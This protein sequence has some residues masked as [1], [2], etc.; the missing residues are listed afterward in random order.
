MIGR[1]QHYFAQVVQP[2]WP[3]FQLNETDYVVQF[4]VFVSVNMIIMKSAVGLPQLEIGLP[5]RLVAQVGTSL[6][7]LH[8]RG[9]QVIR[10]STGPR[11][12]FENFSAPTAIHSSKRLVA[13]GIEEK[14]A[15][16]DR[17]LAQLEEVFSEMGRCPSLPKGL[18]L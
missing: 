4:I 3:A 18:L 12:P 8:T 5:H 13:Q 6:P 7:P 17:E 16:S 10:T 2:I 11:S 1:K 14:A 9:L 15:F